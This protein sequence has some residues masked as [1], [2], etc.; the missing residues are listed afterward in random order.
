VKTHP[1]VKNQDLANLPESLRT[2]FQRA[3]VPSL[4]IDPYGCNGIPSHDLER[5]LVGWRALE[6]EEMG[7][8]YRLVYRIVEPLERRCVEIVSFDAHDPAYDKAKDRTIS[9]RARSRAG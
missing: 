6:I 1:L 5:E 2:G 8:C 3:I 4:S 9:E 7:E